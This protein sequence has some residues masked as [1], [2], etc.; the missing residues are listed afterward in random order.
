MFLLLKY[1]FK[2]GKSV[3]AR[4]GAFRAHYMLHWNYAVP[5]RKSIIL[6]VVNIKM[7][8]TRSPGKPP[9]T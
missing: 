7:I 3:I 9:T 4:Q 2:T 1:L 6:W 5:H 8:K